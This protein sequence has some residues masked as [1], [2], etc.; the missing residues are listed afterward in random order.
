MSDLLARGARRSAPLRRALAG[1][2]EESVDPSRVVTPWGILRS[3]L[4]V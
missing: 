2:L 3:L 1:I 4:S